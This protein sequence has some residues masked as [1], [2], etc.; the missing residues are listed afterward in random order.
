MWTAFL[1][2]VVPNVV[3][4]KDDVRQE[5]GFTEKSCCERAG[6]KALSCLVYLFGILGAI[7]CL[8]VE[9]R[10]AYLLANAW[11]VSVTD[12]RDLIWMIDSLFFLEVPFCFHSNHCNLHRIC[13][14][15]NRICYSLE[16]IW[17]CAACAHYCY[18]GHA[19]SLYL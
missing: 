1:V 8:F 18:F 4:K 3:Q 9:K 2:P 16:C 7:I 19:I 12:C 10:N 13:L 14:V 6:V 11:Q 5:G 15:F 17:P